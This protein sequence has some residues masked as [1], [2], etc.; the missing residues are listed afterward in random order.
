MN[1]IIFLL[2]GL[3][4]GALVSLPVGPIGIMCLRRMILQGPVIGI[5]SGL[6][7]AT[8][9]TIFAFIAMIGLAFVSSLLTDHITII[10]VVSSIFLGILGFTIFFNKPPQ[11]PT[12]KLAH[13]IT[14]SYFSTLMLTLANPLTIIS[15]ITLLASFGID[16]AIVSPYAIISLSLGI[17]L[18]AVA[19]WIFLGIITKPLHVNLKPST[20]S[21]IN[22]AAGLSIIACALIIFFSIFIH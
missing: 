8:A 14:E 4:I 6:G 19:W 18:G 2:K 11:H 5:F 22:H 9:D 20:L 21:F 13:S 15:L 10:R 12:G 16:P 3:I 17:F 7:A 1:S